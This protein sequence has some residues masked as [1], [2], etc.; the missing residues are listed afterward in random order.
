MVVNFAVEDIETAKILLPILPHI[1]TVMKIVFY[2]SKDINLA[3]L[4]L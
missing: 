2:F 1:T 4:F 3:I